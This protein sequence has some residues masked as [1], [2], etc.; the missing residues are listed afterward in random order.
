MIAHGRGVLS[1]DV[2]PLEV[3]AHWMRKTQRMIGRA[4][5]SRERTGEGAFIDVW[6]DELTADPMA[7]VARIYERIGQPLTAD[8]ARRMQAMLKN[9]PQGKYGKH[10]Y[11]LADFGL[12]RDGVEPGYAAY[13]ARFGIRRE[14]LEGDSG[15][16]GA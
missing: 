15:G 3:G 14:P 4:L 11:R 7:Q 6:Y 9:N 16:V 10:I 12:T 2:D 1:D 8:T 5:L 13:R